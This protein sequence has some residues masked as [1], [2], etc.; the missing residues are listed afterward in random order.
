MNGL[1]KLFQ[2]LQVDI[3][4]INFYLEENLRSQVPL[5]S[6]INRHILVGGGK[7]LRAL[8]FVLCS[9]LCGYK[10][11][12]GAH[13][14][15]TI[16]EYLH[17]ATLLHDDVIDNADIRR[18][19]SAAN[20]LWG[21]S[22]SVLVGDFLLA[23]SFDLA[24][25]TK[26]LRFLQIL[27]KTT[28]LMAEGMVSELINSYNLQVSED[29]YRDI[30]VNKTAVL[31]SAACQTGAII[32]NPSRKEES[33]LGRYGMELGIAFQI[34]DDLLDYTS[35]QKDFGKPVANDFKEGK[36]TLPLIYA[37]QGC[38]D[39]I[40]K[41]IG[42]ISKKREFSEENIEFVFDLVKK[43]GGIE[44]TLR[45]AIEAKEKAQKF[46]QIFPPSRNRQ[47]LHDLAEFVVER[48]R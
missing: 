39:R 13:Y 11:K 22:A 29:T 42:I 16:F 40:K 33:A 30:L 46:L 27:S 17:G 36:I 26:N 20:I 48:K 31:I 28:M 32:G 7:R 21:N 6:E 3:D 18:G 47:I 15:A 38:S 35:T 9:R 4:K 37:M 45:K 12:E 23:K 5:V 34:I 44:F 14:F 8:L 19:K 41:K 2:I 24:V 10:G 25:E 1:D 43:S